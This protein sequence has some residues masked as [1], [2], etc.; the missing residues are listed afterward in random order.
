MRSTAYASTLKPCVQAELRQALPEDIAA[1][2]LKQLQWRN[3]QRVAQSLQAVAAAAE[4]AETTQAA[5][6]PLFEAL[7]FESLLDDAEVMAATETAILVL[8][9]R[10]DLVLEDGGRYP[11]VYKLLGHGNQQLRARV[12]TLI[13]S[14]QANGS[15]QGYLR[16]ETPSVC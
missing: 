5:V 14:L 9:D 13:A 10:H 15:S 12:S 3:E 4:D 8:N 1:K 6:T 16:Q 2:S 7:S 11:G